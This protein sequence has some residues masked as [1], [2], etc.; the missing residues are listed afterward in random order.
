MKQP[1]YPR[2][3][4]KIQSK[5]ILE[6]KMNFA[7]DINTARKNKQI[8]SISDNQVI[9]WIDTINNVDREKTKLKYENNLKKIKSLKKESGKGL[10][11]KELYKEL[12]DI[13][14][15]P[16]LINVVMNKA[17]DIDKLKSGFQVNGKTY[18]RFIGSPNQVKKST[19]MYTCMHDELNRL[20]E[21][22]RNPEY[23]IVPA[24]Y[25]AYKALALSGSY[26][27]TNTN[28]ILV[29]DDL[30]THF[31]EDVI[32]LDDSETDEPKME[33]K[34]AEIELDESDG[35]GLIS[36]ELAQIWS[37]DMHL[38]YLLSGCC[39]RHAFTK[40]MV[41]TFDFKEFAKLHNK[42]IVK[43]VWGKE[44]NI[45]DIDIILTTSMLKLWSAYE[46]IDDF[47]NKSHMNN[48]GFCVTK[49]TPKHLDEVRT[50]NY[51]F[52]Q[53]YN[54]TDEQIKELISPTVNELKDILHADINKTILFLKGVKVNENN[55]DVNMNDYVKALMIDNRLINDKYVID[56]INVLISK[57]IQDAKIGVLKVRGNYSIIVGDP[58]ALCQKIFGVNVENDDDYGILKAGEIYHKFWQDKNVNK[59]ACFRAPM[60]CHNNIRVMSIASNDKA[61]YWYRYCPNLMLLN[62]H[63]NFRAAG[64]GADADGDIFLTTD[65]KVLVD[66]WES[67]PTIMCVQ[68]SAEKFVVTENLLRDSNK[69][70][71]GSKVGA[72]TNRVTSMFDMLPLFDKDSDEYKTLIY[73]IKCGQLY[74][75]SD[76][77][78]VKGAITKPMPKYWYQRIKPKEG[79]ELTE[80]DIFNN[81]ICVDKKPYFFR[82]I[83]PDINKK[84]IHYTSNSEHKCAFLFD[85]SIDELLQKSEF[86]EEELD[87]IKYYHKYFP[88]NDNGCTMNK[89]CHMVED[90]FKGYASKIKAESEFDY[91]ILKSDCDYNVITYEEI[92]RLYGEYTREKMT[93]SEKMNTFKVL[94][95]DFVKELNEIKSYYKRKCE[96]TC[97]SSEELCNIVIDLCYVHNKSKAFAWDV[98][99]DQIIKNLLDKNNNTLNYLTQSDDGS[100]EYDGVLFERKEFEIC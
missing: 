85:C 96:E 25:E 91:T 51:Q 14:F 99:V 24:K 59:V 36:P 5:D 56:K 10:I 60:S 70:G 3:I 34:T 6:N 8:I 74:Q 22:G 16:E 23:K 72:I 35:Y 83:Y 71:F 15:V 58:Y 86:T 12:D 78:A 20:V 81:S 68:N 84:Y 69:K 17:S 67:T 55:I 89:L 9:R 45:N 42:S 73:R 92:K 39:V 88:V 18:V 46:S 38:D 80:E 33:H 29:V 93:L 79:E 40:G 43:D 94:K 50:L 90:E 44:H 66:N 97:S 54:L 76:I 77:D 53:S 63:D 27:V 11:I 95:E 82:Y 32:F 31:T 49:V 75:Q 4:L 41:A 65:N 2:Y 1:L 26:P 57:K 37:D 64:N 28:R 47:L 7:V 100:I 30:I 87:Y 48:Y 61:N 62:C 19:V 52:I 98:S 13:Q 21:N